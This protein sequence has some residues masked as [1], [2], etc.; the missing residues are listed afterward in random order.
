[1]RTGSPR[2][3]VSLALLELGNKLRHD[4]VVYS[5]S[6]PLSMPSKRHAAAPEAAVSSPVLPDA[7]ERTKDR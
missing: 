3:K 6:S 4:Y 1:M 7:E 5:M 2:S